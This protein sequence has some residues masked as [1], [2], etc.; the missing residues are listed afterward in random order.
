MNEL[1]FVEDIYDLET[2]QLEETLALLN[3]EINKGPNEAQLP[4]GITSFEKF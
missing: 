3:R 4:K 2:H 1:P